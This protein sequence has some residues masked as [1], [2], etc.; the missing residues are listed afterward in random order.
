MI[1]KFEAIFMRYFQYLEQKGK[2]FNTVVGVLCALSVGVID[3][4]TPPAY[5]F[6]LLYVLTISFTS[7]FA[8]K[9]AGL[10][11]AI[12][13][14]MLWA[15]DRFNGDLYASTWN[16]LSAL[17][18]YCFISMLVIRMRKLW[19]IER[20]LSRKDPLTGVMNI[21]AFTEFAEYE[22]LRLQRQCCPF[23]VA[24]LDLDNFKHVNDQY[25]HKKGDELLISVVNCLEEHLRKTDVIARMGGDEFTILLPATDQEAV[26][27]VIQKVREDLSRLSNIN[28]WPTTFSMGVLTCSHGDCSLDEIISR[29][30]KLMYEVKNAGK[31]DVR[32]AEYEM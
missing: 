24:Y 32:Y 22:I 20:T 23:S 9:H 19:E 14:T 26:K 13:C 8:G 31:N 16:I 7:W 1:A 10:I 17:G 15:V 28:K 25:G 21:R 29:A 2:T 5:T 6:G 30:D 27:V 4:M 18:I 3:L 12:C 11:I